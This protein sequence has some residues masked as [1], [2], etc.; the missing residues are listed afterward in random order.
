MLKRSPCRPLALVIGLSQAAAACGFLP[1]TGSGQTH[2]AGTEEQPGPGFALVEGD[3]PRATRPL[4][5]DFVAPEGFVIEEQA[6][7]I[8]SGGAIEASMINLP[9]PMSLRVN[10]APCEGT[11][12]IESDMRTHVVLR[13][14][15]AGC[16]VET[17]SM[18]PL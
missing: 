8:A 3:P 6:A 18:E 5:I 14:E 16:S 15:D 13:V 2:V 12:A 17:T 9:G 1:G 10:G 11:F 7:R 4:V